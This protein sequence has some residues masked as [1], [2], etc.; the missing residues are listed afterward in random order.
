[1]YIKIS[2]T[3]RPYVPQYDPARGLVAEPGLAG[4]NPTAQSLAEALGI[5]LAEIKF[6]M[7]NGRQMPLETA[8]EEDDR[9]AY[10]PAVGGG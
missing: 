6:V 5:P 9:V 4:P 2:S 10:F 7:I 3:L 8:L 1:M